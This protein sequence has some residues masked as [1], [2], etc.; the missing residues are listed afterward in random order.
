MPRNSLADK[1]CSLARALDIVGE[2]WSL[3]VIRDAFFGS[4]R[5]QDFADNLGIARNI[6]SARLKKLVAAGVLARI[7]TEKGTVEYRLTPRGEALQPVLV[8]LMQWGDTH[9]NPLPKPVLLVDKA[10]GRPLAPMEIRAADGR[11][12]GIK[13]VRAVPGPGAD[14][15]LIARLGKRRRTAA[16]S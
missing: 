5:F 1:N 10:E 13:D 16:V 12:L 2:W 8:S 9:A 6:L 4:R 7:E 11:I 14:P 15:S 3:L